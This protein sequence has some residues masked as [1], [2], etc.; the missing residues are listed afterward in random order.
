MF[1]Y[2]HLGD[3]YI[4]V[5]LLMY[6]LICCTFVRYMTYAIHKD[7]PGIIDFFCLNVFANLKAEYLCVIRL[8]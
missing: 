3:I 4:Y 8:L 6:I 5:C 1:M 2:V 7:L